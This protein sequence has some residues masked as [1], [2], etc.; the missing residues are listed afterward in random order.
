MRRVLIAL[1]ATGTVV[2]FGG[3]AL[4]VMHRAGS[5]GR[6]DE[7]ARDLARVCVDAAFD[8]RDGDS[9]ALADERDAPR[10][11]GR[12]GMIAEARR[13]CAA[14]GARRRR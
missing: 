14:E 5:C 1:L 8:A 7:A 9:S 13:L 2:G 11:W 10:G 12:D 6:H 3:G 4:S